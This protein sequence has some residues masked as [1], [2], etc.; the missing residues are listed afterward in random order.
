MGW[1][2]LN[3]RGGEVMVIDPSFCSSFAAS[4][5]LVFVVSPPRCSDV[6]L[7]SER[8][9]VLLKARGCRVSESNR[10][11]RST[12]LEGKEN[13]LLPSVP[14]VEVIGDDTESWERIV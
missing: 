4:T 11:L 6:S 3:S 9:M 7:G 5:S 2:K 14:N 8:S 10:Q 1:Q 13:N 12:C